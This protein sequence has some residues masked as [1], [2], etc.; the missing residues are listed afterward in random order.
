MAKTTLFLGTE[1][2]VVLPL[3]TMILAEGSSA[4]DAATILQFAVHQGKLDIGAM[5]DEMYPSV[6]GT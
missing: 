2:C 1:G 5:L 4:L 6:P 3:R